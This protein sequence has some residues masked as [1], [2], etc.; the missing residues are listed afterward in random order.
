VTTYVCAYGWS[1]HTIYRQRRV[2]GIT[3]A[4]VIAS[5]GDDAALADRVCADLNRSLA[6]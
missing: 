5:F 6:P 3:I 4:V 2:C 1:G